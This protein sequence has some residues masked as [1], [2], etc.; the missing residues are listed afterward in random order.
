VRK[1]GWMIEEAYEYLKQNKMFG[2]N[3]RLSTKEG[4]ASYVAKMMAE[5]YLTA[6]HVQRRSN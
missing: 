3:I 1:I 5:G 2:D 6:T 4:F